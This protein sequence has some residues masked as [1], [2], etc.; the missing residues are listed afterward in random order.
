[1]PSCLGCGSRPHLANC[2]EDTSLSRQRRW[3]LRQKLAGNCVT[4]GKKVKRKV[5]TKLGERTMTECAAC[6]DFR[7]KKEQAVSS[8]A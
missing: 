5:K 7:K 3:Q 1:M 2:P 4:C 8:A 6:G